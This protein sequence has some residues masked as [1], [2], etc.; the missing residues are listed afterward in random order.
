MIVP[1]YF[2]IQAGLLPHALWAA[3]PVLA[4]AYGFSQD[5]AKTE[6]HYFVGFPSYWNVLAIY[7]YLMQIDPGTALWI[8]LGLSAAVFVPLRYIYPSRTRFLRPLN[9]G[10]LFSWV[11]VIS[12][13]GVRPDPDPVWVRASLAGPAY[14]IGLSLLLNI[15]R[16]RESRLHR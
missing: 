6:D 5:N 10:V 8:V 13:I 1:A 3:V 11:L 9:V 7:L 14:Y 12:W 16:V 2:M 15:P 4:S